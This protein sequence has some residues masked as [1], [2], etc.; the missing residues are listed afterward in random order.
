MAIAAVKAEQLRTKIETELDEAI[1]RRE[2][3][4]AIIKK[5]ETISK[6]H[7]LQLGAYTMQRI[8]VYWEGVSEQDPSITS[9]P[10]FLKFNLSDSV[11]T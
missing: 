10:V 2:T 6:I 3:L 4:T 9:M 11:K 1:K 8:I 5:F 7:I